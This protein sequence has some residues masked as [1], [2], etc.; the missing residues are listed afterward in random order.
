MRSRVA[1]TRPT[2]RLKVE[3][4]RVTPLRRGG[5]TNKQFTTS[6][7]ATKESSGG[8]SPG[9]G[10]EA[11]AGFHLVRQ[12]YAGVDLPLQS[13]LRHRPLLGCT[14]AAAP[15]PPCWRS[16]RPPHRACRTNRRRCRP[17]K[18]CHRCC[19]AA[20]ARTGS[21]TAV[22]TRQLT[23]SPGRGACLPR[24]TAGAGALGVQFAAES[25]GLLR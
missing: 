21:S 16:L 6:T 20:T 2:V 23:R 17:S 4:L 18:S 25:P 11:W 14:P 12:L 9:G 7:K 10:P 13:S 24:L 5:T 15:W 8:V 19:R 1:R 3:T 22:A